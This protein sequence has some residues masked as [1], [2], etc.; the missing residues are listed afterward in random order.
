MIKVYRGN[1]VESQHEV[2]I[3]VVNTEG[4]LLY[5]YGN[6]ERATFARSSMKP[7]QAVPLIET[8]AAAFF[9]YE[10]QELAISCASHSGEAYHRETVQNILKKINLDIDALQCGMHPP[11]N[12]EDYKALIRSGGELTP[13]FSN[14]SGKHS[15]MLATS[16]FMKEDHR[17]YREIESAEQQRILKVIS[18]LCETPIDQIGLSVDGCGVPVHRLPLNKTA[19]GYAQLAAGQSANSPEHS[20]ALETL[21][22]AMMKHPEMVGGYQRFDTDLMRMFPN[23]IVSKAGAEGVQCLGV[24]DRGIGIAIKCEDGNPRSLSAVTLKVLEDLG[25]TAPSGQDETYKK[26]REPA[27]K[28]M[29]GDSIGKIEVDLQLEKCF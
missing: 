23:K 22:D 1:Y 15:G 28:N 8:G 6:P 14:C 2:H 4:Q 19:Y 24:V 18:E 25:V 7:F 20:Q 11:K 13:L 3:A 26:Y 9:N 12:P 17:V 10:P 5:Q 27:V 29:R 16:V 21:R